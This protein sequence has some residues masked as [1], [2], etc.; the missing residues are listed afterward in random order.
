[1]MNEKL[2]VYFAGSGRIAVPVLEALSKDSRI[3]LVGVGTQPDRPVGR[4]KVLTPTPLGSAAAGLGVTLHK[5][6]NINAPEALNAIRACGPRMMVVLSYGQL[7]KQSLLELPELG[8]IN[9]HGSLLPRW[10]G[11]SPI[12][13]VLLHREKETGV[14]FMQ[15]EKGLDS[16]PVFKTLTMEIPERCGADELEMKLG[17]LAA[18]HCA[19][20]LLQISSGELTA[21]PQEHDKAVVC[22]KITR[23]DGSVDWSLSA[24]HIEAMSRAFENWPGAFFRLR[25][26]GVESVVTINASCV[27]DDMTGV[28]GTLLTPGNRKKMIV[29]CGSG[30]LELLEVTPAGRKNMPVAAFLNG[31]RGECIEFLPGIQPD[32]TTL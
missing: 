31:I 27:H 14:C 21:I 30:A 7:L 19:E 23:E 4:K 1:M 28:P 18:E 20:T 3:E 22:R 17:E 12:Q 26:D 25:V 5:F 32:N 15:M 11:A 9:I 10:R 2:K 24:A 13:Q 8:C 16:G 6:E 29:A